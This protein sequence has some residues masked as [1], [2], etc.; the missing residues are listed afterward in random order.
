[1]AKNR[2]ISSWNNVGWL[3]RVPTSYT[4]GEKPE[5]L[6]QF[7]EKP[8]RLQ[9]KQRLFKS[10]DHG[11]KALIALHDAKQWRNENLMK[12]LKY[13]DYTAL[14]NNR[15]SMSSK[16][17]IRGND[18]PTGITDSQQLSK[19][20]VTIQRKITVQVM[21][22]WKP[23][24]KSFSYGFIRDRDQ[25]VALAKEALRE[26]HNRIEQETHAKMR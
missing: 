3:V 13:Q 2:Y 17:R 7:A 5:S 9:Y 8:K 18:L 11:G 21:V 12:G 14:A 19:D 15:R 6:F 25:A 16:A 26:I 10:A 20:G 23:F 24:N 22:H 4:E 1:M